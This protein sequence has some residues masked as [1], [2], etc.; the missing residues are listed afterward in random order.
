MLLA[1][2]LSCGPKEDTGSSDD[3][4]TTPEAAG[5]ILVA[6]T[7]SFGELAVGD[8]SVQA[9]LIQNAGEGALNILS[10]DLSDADGLTMTGPDASQL[11]TGGLSQVQL[12]WEPTTP[13]DL[14][15]TLTIHTDDPDSPTTTITLTGEAIG[16]VLT[17]SMDEYDFGQVGVGCSTEIGLTVSNTGNADLTISEVSLTNSDGEFRLDADEY[18]MEIFPWI[19][20]PGYSQDFTLEFAPSLNHETAA[21]VELYSDDAGHPRTQV[22]TWGKGTIEDETTDTF[23]VDEQT[24][25]TALFAMNDAQ[26]VGGWRADVFW[27]SIDVFFDTLLE[28]GVPFRVAF[29]LPTTGAVSGD[30][31]YIDDT[32]TTSDAVAIVEDMMTGGMGDNDEQFNTLNKGLQQQGDWLFEEDGN[33]V[34]SRLSLIAINHDTEQSGGTAKS[35]L[36]TYYGYKD[37]PSKIIFHAIGGAP[38]GSGG[39]LC[40]PYTQPYNAT[41]MTGGYFLDYCDSSW[42]EHMVKIAEAVRGD[43]NAFVLSDN[44][45]PYSIKVRIDGVTLSEGWSYSEVTNAVLFTEEAFP[46]RGSEVTITYNLSGECN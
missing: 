27:D 28:A 13:G 31:P 19:L 16:P 26:I 45:A 15:A 37:D 44:P 3:P 10:A 24:N 20:K 4:D 25:A 41:V 11:T 8:S 36:N 23:D 46:S 32:Y 35:H 43:Y 18:T 12:T 2:L 33:W 40:E 7:V 21:I 6:T 5:D 22:Q 14:D 42:E 34:N 30:V 39:G 17:I 1:L 38:D 9:I 29:L